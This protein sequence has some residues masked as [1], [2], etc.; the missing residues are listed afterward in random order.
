[1]D[2]NALELLR[3][4]IHIDSGDWRHMLAEL[5][6][7]PKS[8]MK[9]AH[10]VVAATALQRKQDPELQLLG[11]E[12]L[13]HVREE[14][15]SGWGQFGAAAEQALIEAL[16]SHGSE[17]SQREAR[18]RYTLLQREAEKDNKYARDAVAK[19]ASLF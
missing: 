4:G 16:M 7:E 9:G 17:K 5:R 19:V 1:M 6:Q 18:Q 12:L 3:L 8:P 2:V 14:C 11:I 10:I 13:R 15:W